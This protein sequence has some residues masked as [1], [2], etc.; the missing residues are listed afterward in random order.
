MV[1]IFLER[2]KNSLVEVPLA[3]QRNSSSAV[4]PPQTGT[5][6]ED[7]AEASRLLGELLET[8]AFI[9]GAYQLEVSSP[10]LDRRLRLKADF[11]G[12]IGQ[13]VKLKLSE[14]IPGVGANLTGKLERV[15]GEEIVVSVNSKEVPVVIGRILR[16]NRVWHFR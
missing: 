11:E 7:C 15:Q 9:P 5:S 8:E 12:N 6:I 2:K 3:S 1:R 13:T 14:S 16:A 4:L 10:G